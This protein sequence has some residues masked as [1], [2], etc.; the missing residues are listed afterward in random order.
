MGW[1][2]IGQGWGKEEIKRTMLHDRW[3]MV[4]RRTDGELAELMMCFLC[5]S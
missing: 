1:L 2:C 4:D 5:R 3:W